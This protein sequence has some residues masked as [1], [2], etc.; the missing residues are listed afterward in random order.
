[1]QIRL[2]RV[3]ASKF[4]ARMKILRMIQDIGLFRRLTLLEVMVCKGK[5]NNMKKD[6]SLLLLVAC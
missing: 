1:M 5:H 2:L 6:E 3:L 4:L